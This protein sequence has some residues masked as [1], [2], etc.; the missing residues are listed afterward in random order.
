MAERER[1]V[2][3][4]RFEIPADRVARYALLGDPTQPIA[5]ELNRL[6]AT[7]ASLLCTRVKPIAGLGLVVVIACGCVSQA[8]SGTHSS[9][10]A[11]AASSAS[12][13]SS[14]VADFDPARLAPGDCVAPSP[15]GG[16]KVH[17]AALGLALTLPAGW[18]EDPANEGKRGDEAT[19]ALRRG[20]AP[21]DVFM[22]VDPVPAT[23]SAH[24]AVDNEASQPGAGN[25]VDKGD[26]TVAGKPAAYF[27]STLDLSLF[28]GMTQTADGY[29]LYVTGVDKLVRV[30]IDL[31]L[32]TALVTPPITRTSAMT[33]VKRIL[34]SWTWDLAT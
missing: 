8:T 12:A 34:G 30:S 11:A 26:C 32:T 9:P 31:G 25:V 22:T 6:E 23:M 3:S 16:S 18:A 2:S 19:L 14:P 1:F 33:D 28:P 5:Q 24:A 29:S 10:A 21:N 17:S 4:Q 15:G 7:S 20:Q 27:E 13:G